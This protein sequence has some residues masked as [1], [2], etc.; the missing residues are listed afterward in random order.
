MFRRLVSASALASASLL[1]LAILTTC[2]SDAGTAGSDSKVS[3]AGSGSAA[4]GSFSNDPDKPWLAAPPDMASPGTSGRIALTKAEICDVVD[5]AVVLSLLAITGTPTTSNWRQSEAS[6][7]CSAKIAVGD[8]GSDDVGFVEWRVLRRFDSFET[9]SGSSEMGKSTDLTISGRPARQFV[10]NDGTFAYITV[11]T[12][13]TW[14]EAGVRDL[15]VGDTAGLATYAT[16]VV[17]KVSAITPARQPKLD[18]TVATPFALSA[19]QVC[20]LMSDDVL[21]RTGELQ[22]NRPQTDGPVWSDS[23]ALA[24]TI[25]W[26]TRGNGATRVTISA[27]KPYDWE[28]TEPTESGYTQPATF[29]KVE[30]LRRRELDDAGEFRKTIA[31]VPFRQFWVEVEIAFAPEGR[32]LDAV[33][34]Q[35]VAEVLTKLNELVA[36]T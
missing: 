35:E 20:S 32:K 36:P 3:Q 34:N 14:I 15:L 12:G 27:E 33:L 30:G 1:S 5:P 25:A 22:T 6:S 16:A 10:H 7:E 9:T 2:S 8:V 24:D 4:N 21:Q 19:G 31:T 13:D 28:G 18:Q 17:E 26:C 23:Y 29:V 11:D